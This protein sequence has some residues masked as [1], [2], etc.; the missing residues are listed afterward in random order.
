ME[1][2]SENYKRKKKKKKRGLCHTV[3]KMAKKKKL[4][5][6]EFRLITVTEE[7]MPIGM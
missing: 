7:M 4:R 2:S 1:L 5:G 6:R 3:K